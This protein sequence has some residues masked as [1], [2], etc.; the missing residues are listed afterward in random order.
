MKPIYILFLLCLCFTSCEKTI[1]EPDGLWTPMKWEKTS[2]ETIKDNNISYYY[3]PRE[4]ASFVFV[5]KNYHPWISDIATEISGEV[6][7]SYDDPA[8]Q[9]DP[10]EYSNGWLYVQVAKDTVN[11]RITANDTFV[12]RINLGL[13]AGDIF[14]DI[15]FLQATSLFAE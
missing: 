1:S 15:Q 6:T 14:D 4:G 9:E 8:F 11:V 3:V 13:T 7:H 12:K 5:C 2:Y 10:F